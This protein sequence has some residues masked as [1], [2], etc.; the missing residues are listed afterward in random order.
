MVRKPH[1]FGRCF[2][3]RTPFRRKSLISK[4]IEIMWYLSLSH[5]SCVAC[6]RA[7]SSWPSQQCIVS[8]LEILRYQYRITRDCDIEAHS[9]DHFAFTTRFRHRCTSTWPFCIYWDFNRSEGIPTES[10]VSWDVCTPIFL[11]CIFGRQ[12]CCKIYDILCFYCILI[13]SDC[14]FFSILICASVRTSV[15]RHRRMIPWTKHTS[16]LAVMSNSL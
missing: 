4:I 15:L 3:R 10:E 8:R 2:I 1:Q 5:S 13:V 11:F 16:Y 14:S 9:R 6:F 12:S 7:L